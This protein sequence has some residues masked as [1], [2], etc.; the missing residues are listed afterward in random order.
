MPILTS[1]CGNK[2]QASIGD[3]E[4]RCFN[5]GRGG[6]MYGQMVSDTEK[7][8]FC[9][10]NCGWSFRMRQYSSSASSARRQEPRTGRHFYVS[11]K[12]N[13]VPAHFKPPVYPRKPV[14]ELPAFQN[15][16]CNSNTKEISITYTDG[17]FDFFE[18]MGWWTET[19]LA[20][21]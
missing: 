19:T 1:S 7:N 20:L 10:E 13:R 6:T 2:N 14:A 9:S 11:R 18:H 4:L 16:L 21:E 5:C 17:L 12:N 3:G 15:H 8:T